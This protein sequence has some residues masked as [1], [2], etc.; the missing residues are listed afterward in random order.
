MLAQW[1]VLLIDPKV[2]FS[3]EAIEFEEVN[4]PILTDS[5][6]TIT[7]L[8]ISGDKA[9]VITGERVLQVC[10]HCI[11]HEKKSSCNGLLRLP[12]FCVTDRV[13]V[14][15]LLNDDRPACIRTITKAIFLLSRVCNLP[16]YH[17]EVRVCLIVPR[18]DQ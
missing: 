11:F 7:V 17:A 13:Q 10:C 8:V 14:L 18:L 15:L 16:G 9:D 1:C 3:S 5:Y 12:S 4:S 2:L 6:G